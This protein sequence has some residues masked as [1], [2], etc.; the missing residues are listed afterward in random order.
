MSVS[1]RL[2]ALIVASGLLLLACGSGDVAPLESPAGPNDLLS[3]ANDG[4]E[5][6]EEPT[7]SE[8][9]PDEPVPDEAPPVEPTPIEPVLDEPPDLEPELI[10]PADPVPSPPPQSAPEVVD[11]DGVDASLLRRERDAADLAIFNQ[12]ALATAERRALPLIREIPLF[13]IDRTDVATLFRPA[14]REPD[15]ERAAFFDQ[16]LPLL[17][18]TS[19]SWLGLIEQAWV[20]GLIA[21]Y[22]EEQEAMVLVSE[23]DTIREGD[24][25]TLVHEVVHALQDQHF[26]LDLGLRDAAVSYDRSQAFL[27]VVEGDARHSE[28]FAPE[29]LAALP[30]LPAGREQAPG[31]DSR[32][33][34]LITDLF[35][36]PYI[37]GRGIV[38]TLLEGDDFAVVNSFLAEPPSTTEQL[39]HL[40]VPDNVQAQVSIGRLP[41]APSPRRGVVSVRDGHDG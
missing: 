12:I 38:N 28:Q 40:E 36:A 41:Q 6:G 29:I 13:Y 27:F 14:V 1:V 2:L 24:V 21:V 3:V 15:R 31:L 25:G 17:D 26:D 23:L 37:V 8:S 7:P 4:P 22:F 34:P 32:F 33:P 16:A 5:E 30:P 19:Q 20:G 9:I 35:T 18:V 11:W 10:A 39:L